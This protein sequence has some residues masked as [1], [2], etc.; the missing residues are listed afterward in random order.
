VVTPAATRRIAA[1]AAVAGWLIAI[2]AT[3]GMVLWIAGG[4]GSGGVIDEVTAGERL[5]LAR[6]TFGSFHNGADPW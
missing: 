4:P 3:L 2:A 5:G 6:E 1:A